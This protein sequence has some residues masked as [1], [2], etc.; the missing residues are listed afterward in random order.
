MIDFMDTA[1]WIGTV[2]GAAV[3]VVIRF[4]RR[5]RRSRKEKIIRI[6]E[7]LCTKF[8]CNRVIMI[9]FHNGKKYYTGSHSSHMTVWVEVVSGIS[10]LIDHYQNVEVPNEMHHMLLDIREKGHAFFE[11]FTH[12]QDESARARYLAASV[13]AMYMF[14]VMNRGNIKF[15]ISLCWPEMREFKSKDIEVIKQEIKLIETLI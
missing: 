15:T 14:P 2:I 4:L 5:S 9:H 13:N 12:I 7:D 8:E 3:V 10:R 6:C 11:T 1:E